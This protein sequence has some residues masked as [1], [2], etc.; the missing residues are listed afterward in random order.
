MTTRKKVTED[1]NKIIAQSKD[2]GKDIT[3]YAKHKFS[4]ALEHSR[5]AGGS[6]EKTIHDILDAS[7]ARLSRPILK[8]TNCLKTPPML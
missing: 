5:K 7:A 1:V 6:I 8:V 3:A 2:L 4:E